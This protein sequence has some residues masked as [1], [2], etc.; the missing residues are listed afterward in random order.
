[1]TSPRRKLARHTILAM[2][3]IPILVALVIVAT[4]WDETK[5]TW[6]RRADRTAIREKAS[7]H[8][9]T[10]YLTEI[11]LQ[12]EN[13]PT[14]REERL[15]MRKQKV[16]PKPLRI[17][18]TSMPQRQFLH[19][20]HM[21]TGG[22]SLDSF[23]RCARD[24][25]E[26][27]H[28]QISELLK[29]LGE[30]K[31]PHVSLHE[32]SPKHYKTCRDDT[33]STCHVSASQSVMMSYCAP[34][35]DLVNFR[36]LPEITEETENPFGDTDKYFDAVTVLRHPV[37]RVWS[38]FR[39]QTKTCFKCTPLLEIYEAMEES[40][41]GNNTKL[42]ALG[43][44]GQCLDQL[45]NHQVTNLLS[46][47]RSQSSSVDDMSRLREAVHNLQHSFTILGLTEELPLT[48]EIAG[49]V[50]EEWLP[51]EVPWSHRSCKLEHRNAS[52]SNNRCRPGNTHWDLPSHPDDATRRA[53]ERHNQLD[54][55]L[56]HVARKEFELQRE[57]LGL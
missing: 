35:A 1:M 51:G 6:L 45:Q 38:M 24:R 47:R 41:D 29:T 14:F 27:D 57:A 19:L 56:Y 3:L 13:D 46:T 43:L 33:N 48:L 39:F 40:R 4:H 18:K 31:I 54:L 17:G 21:K 26:K 28:P 22:T 30:R 32:C 20:H 8:T 10:N 34:L 44:N 49:K 42:H 16:T 23:L 37:D 7:N 55:E 50:F 5:E 9:T 52:P 25:L 53:I 12:Y 11:P 15:Q 2:V 36:W